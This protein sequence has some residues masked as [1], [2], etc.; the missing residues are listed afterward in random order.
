MTDGTPVS[1]Q[2]LKTIHITPQLSKG[3]KFKNKIL[4]KKL[5][6]NAKRKEPTFIVTT[7]CSNKDIAVLGMN[8]ERKCLSTVVLIDKNNKWHE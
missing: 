3:D 2:F 1:L 8:L 4:K 5:E 7:L 6:D